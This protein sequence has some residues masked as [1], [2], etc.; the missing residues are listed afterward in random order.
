MNIL[1]AI[2]Q[3]LDGKKVYIGTVALFCVG[4]LLYLGLIDAKTAAAWALIIG[5]LTGAAMRLAIS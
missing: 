3:F 1:K 5:S 2:W 4:G